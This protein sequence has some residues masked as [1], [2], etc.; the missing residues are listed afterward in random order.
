MENKSVPGTLHQ[1]LASAQTDYAVA[2]NAKKESATAF[3]DLYANLLSKDN[4]RVWNKIVS[5]IT[6]EDLWTD[7]NGKEHTGKCSKSHKS[8][9]DGTGLHLLKVFSHN[10]TKLQ[11]RYI[12]T[13]IKKPQQVSI[14]HF[15]QHVEQLNGYLPHLPSIYYSP[16][17]KANTKPVEPFNEAELSIHILHMIPVLWANQCNM[18][19]SELPMHL[20]KLPTIL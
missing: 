15:F 16:K 18:S 2:N 7:L 8:F 12:S 13:V 4:R 17:T 1:Q 10:A 5:D 14:W 6:D 11:H 20:N 19:H 3:F 9:I